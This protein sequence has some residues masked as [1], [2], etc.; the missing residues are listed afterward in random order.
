MV[1]G[2]YGN[3]GNYPGNYGNRSDQAPTLYQNY[4]PPKKRRA[5]RRIITTLIVLAILL[6]GL[7][8]AA[9]AFA[10]SE[11]ATQIQKHGFPKKPS[12]VIAGFPFLTQVAT[13]HFQQITISSGNIP[14]GPFT[15]SKLTFVAANVH[16]NSNFKGGTAGPL[17]GTLLISLGALGSALSDAGPL[18]SFL[19]GGKQAL[20]IVSVGNNE[21]KGSLKLAGGLVSESATWKVESGGP[22]KINLHLVSSSGLGGGLLGA[23]Q[24]VSIPLPSLPAGLQLTGG[25]NSSSSGITAHVFASSFSFGS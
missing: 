4:Q 16:L 12:V 23:A 9:K 6:V 24:N 20:K 1:Y 18:T 15:I 21:I 17:N 5:G 2:N 25:L 3:Q 19:G 13:R 11:A 22:N 10:E 8:F 14:E 7:D